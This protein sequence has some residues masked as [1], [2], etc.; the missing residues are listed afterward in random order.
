[1]QTDDIVNLEFV[2]DESKQEYISI[3]SNPDLKN[4]II[5]DSFTMKILIILH[6]S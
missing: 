5:T 4:G 6:P 3:S 1:M 2:F